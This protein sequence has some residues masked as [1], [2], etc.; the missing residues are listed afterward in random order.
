MLLAILILIAVLIL[1]LILIVL[2]LILLIHDL[3]PPS[4]CYGHAVIS[5]CPNN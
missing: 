2:V 4:V 5:V 3:I 1:G